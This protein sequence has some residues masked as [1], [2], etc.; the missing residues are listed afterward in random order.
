M[1]ND[2]KI[3]S[4]IAGGHIGKL[5]DGESLYLWFRTS[6]KLLW[7]KKYKFE[8]KE[9]TLSIGSYPQVSLAEARLKSREASLLLRDGKDPNAEKRLQRLGVNAHAERRFE[10]VAREWFELS[11]PRWAPSY[12]NKVIG[13][14]KRHAFA[15]VGNKEIDAIS[16]PQALALLRRVE[17]AGTL[18]TAHRLADTCRRVCA[19]GKRIGVCTTNPFDDL[20]EALQRPVPTHMPALLT[21]SELGEYLNNA[22]SYRGSAVVRIAL[23]LLPHLLLRPGELRGGSWAEVDFEAQ[24]WR[25]PA[26]RMK[27]RKAQKEKNPAHIVPLSD[28]VYVLLRELYAETGGS[29]SGLMF[30]GMRPGRPISDGTLNQ[31]LRVM[32]YNTMKT[33]TAHGFRATARTLAIERLKED[34]RVVEAQLAHMVKTSLGRSYDRTEFLDDRA[35]FMERWSAYLGRLAG[36]SAMRVGASSDLSGGNREGNDAHFQEILVC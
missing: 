33:V 7:H 13:R 11:K 34:E 23:Q 30:E 36:S 24:E 5:F 35:E 27:L 10:N 31:A 6:G 22:R 4:A 32:G 8:G 2:K 14:L 25:V 29:A 21:E 17:A 26:R 15:E 3:K 9:N 20:A 1:I 18:E 19:H 12:A 28:P 16:T